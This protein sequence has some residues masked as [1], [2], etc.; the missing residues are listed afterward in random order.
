L[1]LDDAAGDNRDHAH[2]FAGHYTARLIWNAIDDIF[3]D[4]A[5]GAVGNLT[6]TSF[7][8]Q[9]SD[10][11]R[12]LS[13]DNFRDAPYHLDWNR[14][15]DDL[16][17]IAGALNL[18]LHRLRTVDSLAGVEPRTL[19]HAG[20]RATT[21]IHGRLR[22]ALARMIDLLSRP[23]WD[24]LSHSASF[25]HRAHDGAAARLIDDFG[26][27]S[28]HRLTTFTGNRLSDGT[29]YDV[30]FS[31]NLVLPDGPA[32]HASDFAIVSF[33]DRVVRRETFFPL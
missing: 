10:L 16:G 31:A 25:R 15:I 9:S 7:L 4:P 29:T 3:S 26:D 5:A 23:I 19:H 22:N 20:S 33:I 8:N 14:F 6:L 21:G 12:N 27:A 13:H 32:D 30:V 18:T 24:D 28:H 11:L 2:V 1:F 17:D